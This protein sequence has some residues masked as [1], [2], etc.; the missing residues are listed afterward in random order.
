MKKRVLCIVL[1]LLMVFPLVFAAFADTGT[2]SRDR[3]SVSLSKMSDG[4]TLVKE[5]PAAKETPGASDPAEQPEEIEPAEQPEE[6]EEPEIVEPIDE[7]EEIDEPEIV[8]EDVEE[9]EEP[10]EP[11]GEAPVDDIWDQIGAL[12]ENLSN[13][14]KRGA[15]STEIQKL[16]AADF[17][18]LT[19]NVQET[20]LNWDGY[21]DGS[22]VRNGDVLFW[23]GEDGIPYGYFPD[24]REKLYNVQLTAS[25]GN[26]HNRPRVLCYDGQNE[27]EIPANQISSIE[28]NEN[29]VAVF[30]PLYHIDEGFADEDEDGL[31]DFFGIKY[32][33]S[34]YVQGQKIANKIN[35]INTVMHGASY[36]N[37]TKNMA[38]CYVFTQSAASVDMIA[39]AL[40]KCRVVFI[41]THGI[42]DYFNK[43]ADGVYD[44]TSK[45]NTSYI[46]LTSGNSILDY[47]WHTGAHDG[48]NGD[49]QYRHAYAGKIP[50]GTDVWCVDGTTIREAAD[51]LNWPLEGTI[52]TP[53]SGLET[54]TAWQPRG[55][56][57]PCLP[58]ARGLFMDIRR[59]LLL[60][61]TLNASIISGRQ[62]WK[63][64][65]RMSVALPR[66]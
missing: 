44:R 13:T 45:A 64:M 48:M 32:G 4:E 47:G 18:A 54:A 51:A 28:F 22:L 46:M 65:Q 36:C 59:R 39:Q 26:D 11:E 41:D 21:V 34:Y 8:P 3:G 49:K 37:F 12:E 43:G 6:I 31:Y 9:P 35:A 40:L 56:V 19:D 53:L 25:T 2:G 52:T 55:F 30:G 20:V 42:T 62:C 29:D 16:T 10:D 5:T 7:P 60:N 23:E 24:A 66:P 63:T 50:D 14:G 58:W 27:T 33:D 38:H 17:A 61:T 57:T 1:A 15:P